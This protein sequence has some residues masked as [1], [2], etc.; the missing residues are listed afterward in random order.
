VAGPPV[1][2]PI[3]GGDAQSLAELVALATTVLG[4]LNAWLT[5]ATT[6][7]I[8]NLMVVANTPTLASPANPL[9]KYVMVRN[10]DPS[11]ILYYGDSVQIQALVGTAPNQTPTQMTGWQLN[12]GEGVT[13]YQNE[14][15][16]DLWLYYAGTQ[17]TAASILV[18][19]S[20][21]IAGR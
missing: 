6:L 14:Y 18:D 16:G 17:Y 9:R 19:V 11:N 20:D 7:A 8:H 12:P 4:Q 5:P 15:S 2:V 3:P 13:L 10:A 1:C 21:P